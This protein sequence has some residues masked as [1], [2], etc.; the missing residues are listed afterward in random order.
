MRK[1]LLTLFSVALLMGCGGTKTTFQPPSPVEEQP[2]VGDFVPGQ[3]AID[4]KDGMSEK[5]I[6]EMGKEYGFTIRDSS[7]LAHDLGNLEVADVDPEQEASILGKLHNDPRVEEVEPTIMAHAFFTPNDPMYKD[8][9]GM[10]AVGAVDAWDYSYSN[11]VVIAVVDTGIDTTLSDL[12]DNNFVEGYNFIDG[13]NKPLDRNSHGS[14]V[15]GSCSQSSNNGIGTIGVGP[16][17]RLMPVKVLSDSG[18]GSMESVAGGIRFAADHGANVINLSLG[19]SQKSAIV[20]KSVKYAHDKGVIVMAAAGNDN[21]QITGSPAADEFAVAVAATDEQGNKASF[22]SWGKELKIAAPGVAILQQTVD[23][24]G[25]GI[26]VYA[27]YSGTSMATPIMAGSI[28]LIV[29]QGITDPDAAM[30][31]MQ[32]TATEKN[33]PI[34]FGAGIVSASSAVKSAYWNHLLYRLAFLGLFSFILATILKKNGKTLD[35]HP[36]KYVGALLASVGLFFFLPLTGLLPHMGSFRWIGEILSRPL[37]DM[38]LIFS[39]AAHKYLLLASAFPAI[40]LVALGYNKAILRSLAGGLAIGTCAY[41]AQVAWSGE[42]LF[43]LGSLALKVWCV[44]NIG[45]CMWV[46][47]NSLTK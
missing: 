35:P 27:K 6:A 21:R 20:A 9:W 16:G 23:R 43:V 4:L 1:S 22:S 30:S 37:G 31:V 25:K 18:S 19:S 8:Q 14:H 40:L 11:G 26:P 2:A 47:K 3:I 44:I 41:M 46:A 28:S 29:S 36:A 5:D 39:V 10:V 15:A 42:T 24:E 33:D 13:N 45:I 7:P 38:D 17:A 32:K 12:K 34:H